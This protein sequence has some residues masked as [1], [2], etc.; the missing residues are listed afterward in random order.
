MTNRR[1]IIALLSEGPRTP[2]SVAR[3]LRLDRRDLYTELSHALQSVRAAGHRV[4]VDPATCVS[5]GFV[6]AETTLHKPGKCP[7]CR[8][9]R[10]RE[11]RLRIE[12]QPPPASS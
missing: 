11:P 9:T 5:C 1:K 7:S 4:I 10:V 2:T 8:G 3:Q 6:F 12:A